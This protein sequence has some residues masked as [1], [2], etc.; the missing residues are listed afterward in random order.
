MI[1]ETVYFIIVGFVIGYFAR[2]RHT[3]KKDYY[4]VKSNVPLTCDAFK[5]IEKVDLRYNPEACSAEIR[6]GNN[7][8]TATTTSW[9]WVTVWEK[10]KL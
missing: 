5:D 1:L 8:I 10:A 2:K 7:I 6:T 9:L 4:P 3:F